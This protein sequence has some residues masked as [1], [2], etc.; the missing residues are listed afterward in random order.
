M[1]LQFSHEAGELIGC[2][3]P[4]CRQR[5]TMQLGE[6]DQESVVVAGAVDVGRADSPETYL[7]ESS[8]AQQS[9]QP[10]A[11]ANIEAPAGAKVA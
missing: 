10:P 9:W 3:Q 1:G 8:A 7:A 5:C 6:G 4:I 2:Y 11:H